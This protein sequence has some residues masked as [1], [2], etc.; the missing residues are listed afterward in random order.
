MVALGKSL[1]LKK[2][3]DVVGMPERGRMR[4][5][6]RRGMSWWGASL[7]IVCL[8]LA[9]ALLLAAPGKSR[10]SGCPNEGL[11]SGPSAE[12]PDCRAYELV[13]PSQSNGRLLEAINTFALGSPFQLF[14]TEFASPSRD[15]ILYMTY[16]SPLSEPGEGT[17][18]FD[19]YE[20]VRSTAGWETMRRVTPSGEQSSDVLP[21]G[22]AADHSYA[23]V[24][25]EGQVGSLAGNGPV[26][27]L[28]KPDGTFE[29]TGTGSLGSEPASQGRYIS[30]GG[31]HV[32]FSTGLGESAT[33][34][35][36]QCKVRK[37]EPNAPESGTGAIY[38]RS[39]DGSTHVVSLLPPSV[40]PAP[41]Q[42]ASYRGTSKNA[43]SV[44]F[45]IEGTLHVRVNN[46]QPSEE[47][48]KV[49]EDNPAYGGLS[50]DGDYLFYVEGGE[51]GTIHR[52][53]TTD[54][55][56]ED[57][58]PTAAGELVNVSADG[59][60]VYFI[61]EETIGGM[62]EIG[63]PNLFVWAG[64]TTEYVTTVAPSDLERTSGNQSG[65]CAF[66]IYCGIPAL[67]RWTSFAVAPSQDVV[68]GPGAES[69]RTTPDGRVLVFESRAQL[70]PSY[71]ND[72][73]T[74]IYRWD[75]VAKEL[76]C[77]SCNFGKAASGD[78]RLQELNLIQAPIVINNLSFDGSRVFFETPEALSSSDTDGV[79]DIYEW[80]EGGDGGAAVL[81]SSGKS[82][83]YE[84]L[85]VLPQAPKP[86]LLLSV[87]PSAGD[88]V[89]IS[90]DALVPG[91]GEGGAPAIYDARVNGGFAQPAAPAICLEEGCRGSG[92]GSEPQLQANEASERASG[93]GNLKPRK[94]RR[95]H[96]TRKGS[97]H[98]GCNKHHRKYG[99]HRGARASSAQAAGA[100]SQE[101]QS[102]DSA[103]AAGQSSLAAAAPSATTAASGA[104]PY[105]I[106]S[107][108][109]SET[110]H[111]AGAHP[112]FKTYLVLNQY[113]ENGTARAE[114]KTE[115][116][117]VSLP[118]GLLGDVN[119]SERCDTGHLLAFSNCPLKSQVGIV[120]GKAELF[121]KFSAPLYN[122]TPPHPKAE[123]ARLGFTGAFYP[124]FIDIH[125]R[126][127]SDYGV[128][129]TVH[130]LP[131]LFPVLNAETI[132]W[133]SP[134]DPV[135]DP[136]RLLATEGNCPGVICEIPEG[137]REIPRTNLA[138]MTNP[139]ACQEGSVGFAVKSYQLPGKVFE[140]SAPL[141][142]VT[143]CVGLPFA[144]RIDAEP[145]NHTAGAATGLEAKLVL[146]QHL[147]GDERATATMRE[148]R[149]TLPAGMHIAAGAAN[150]I[151]TC[152]EE[153]VG[154][155]R[156]VDAAC[157]DNSKLG[158]A[159]IV[160]PA[161]P[162]PLQGALY[163]RTPAPGHQFGLWLTSDALGLHIKIPG[164]LEPDP[165]SGRLTAVF[166][167]LPEVPVE[168][169]DLDVWG[170]P[171][172]PLQ[173]PDRCGT[174]TTD[175]SFTPHS[176]DPAATG[177]SQMT[178]DQG[179]DQ[180]FNPSL[181]AGVT[182]PVAGGF[183]PFVFDM[184]KGD[185]QQA[186]RGFELKLPDGELAKLKGVPLC[187]DA[188]AQDARC[189]ADSAIGHLVAAT[190]PG[191]EPL[192]IPQPGK[193]EPRVY[194]AGADKGSPFSI[195]T[196]VPAQAGPF[197]LGTVVVRSG[198]GLDP[199]T[200]RA[201][202]DADP[203]PQFFEGVGLTYRRLH[204]VV[205]RPGFSL[206][207]TDCREMSV[208]STVTSTK[209]AV[210]HPAARFQVDGCKG[211]KFKPR[212]KL[213]LKGGTERGSYPALIAVLKARK[214]DANIAKTSVALP[215]SE[216]LAQEHIGTI[217]TRKQFAA[218]K[219]PKRSVYGQ[220]KAWTPL[221]AEPLEGPVYLRSSEHPLPD[222][223]AALGG[224]LDVNLA[225]RIDSTKAG[226][227][228]TTFE[229][230]P[231]APVTKFVLK[232]SRGPK[233]LLVN[234][235]NI[236][237]GRHRSTVRMRAQNGRALDL[238]PALS[239]SGCGKKGSH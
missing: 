178:I 104:H 65:K 162:E 133:G 31:E 143:D 84:P 43:A 39:V 208:D 214:G 225:G 80:I 35:N 70:D 34:T 21:G 100:T 88:V 76:A 211:L 165:T 122:L 154:Y 209:G 194:L 113:E 27:Y 159:T 161:L 186:V 97:K 93:A 44:A 218:D 168:E 220:A 197:D 144:P 180:S 62:G 190:G 224:E 14:P 137:K 54:G 78:A 17:G 75:D 202:V 68:K 141:A 41:G 40:T 170:G 201:V 169:V 189:P 90:Q 150:W 45:Q 217:C 205:D 105:G 94:K 204:V 212:L 210:V 152:S 191:P 142:P 187:P 96:R 92:S 29:L 82:I 1:I 87:T 174:F 164:E 101:S 16:V 79:N 219:C 51:K 42:Q 99:R 207:P 216:F 106:E 13:S 85:A 50:A 73:H 238:R 47:T 213:K 206:N 226:G 215:H 151:G 98:R 60:H 2:I 116:I 221:L 30:E 49:A 110:T 3:S 89:F 155:H 64:G 109:A 233:S 7:G 28:G 227:I 46:G 145:T 222:L 175:F 111:A 181:H 124:V 86:N 166:K 114:G 236:C 23:F 6:S 192:W 183:S 72:G 63:K 148:A 231:D 19:L 36:S 153:Q 56:D 102:R 22:S 160:S 228:R 52:F 61:S 199:D 117:S 172:A 11:R 138:F 9:T 193:P 71:D 223:V 235:T 167:D 81:I 32:I 59:S 66:S 26:S 83:E 103:P 112:D 95:C 108:E 12:L 57:A 195:V 136:Q 163:Q 120:R 67:T 125:V 234:S 20:A 126:T 140:K 10:A 203:L 25:V 5:S 18:K 74:E 15:S 177:Q 147:G 188:A 198:L 139:S 135:H 157:P 107:V 127:A 4:R 132:L 171:R 128:T 149:V 24:E 37:L 200:N 121:A 48:L 123:V 156:E 173:N 115:E 77:V 184:T 176:S 91:A 232:M 58:N 134:S 158:T 55:S 182:D 196:E 119:A 53:D 229:S 8:L 130:G 239:S 179:C 146:P 33:C 131:G 69:S 129:A 230:V 237:H 185:G 118:P 38:D